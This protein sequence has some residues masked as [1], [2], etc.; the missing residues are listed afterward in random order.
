MG[1]KQLTTVRE[2]LLRPIAIDALRPTQITVGMR[3]VEA[4]RKHWRTLGSGKEAE[5]LGKHMIPVILGPK[6]RHYIIDHHHLVRALYEE[7]VKELLVIVTA[8][9][10]ALPTDAF[11]FVLDNR[12]WIHPFDEKGCR[13]AYAD[14]P[15]SVAKLHDDPFRS[16]ASQL[17]REGGYAK[18]TTPYSEFLWADFLRRKMTRQTV[19]RDFA[20][21]LKTALTLAKS[22]DATYLPGW[23]G[24]ISR[25]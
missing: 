6:K 18:D 9:L 4:R 1:A 8:D 22:K 7:G 14:I 23:A 10:S 19:E 24:R 17:R 11:W 2:P 3:E 15:K 25:D 5:Y 16:L 20:R 13:R 12:A 21:A